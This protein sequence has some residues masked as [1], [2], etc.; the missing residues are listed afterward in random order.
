MTLPLISAD[1]T[2][3]LWAAMFAIAGFSIWS[4]KTKFGASVSGV[5][6]AIALAILASNVMIIPRSAPAYDLVNSY[7]LP[8]AIPM[9][10]LKANLRK[11]IR[12]TKGMLIAFMFGTLGTVIGV[13]IGV[14]L[15]PLGEASH[16]LAGIFSAT[17][18]G[19]SMNMAAVAQVVDIDP[20]LLSASVAADNV[21]GVLYLGVLATMPAIKFIRRFFPSD[22]I[23]QADAQLNES[24]EQAASGDKRPSFDLLHICIML[25]LS[26][27]ICA[28]GKAI[29]EQLSIANY[30]ILFITAITVLI[31]NVFPNHLKKLHGEYQLGMLFMYLFF[32]IA[33]AGADIPLMISGA[34]VLIPFTIIIVF[35]HWLIILGGGKL[36][37]IDL[38]EI[39]IASNACAAGPAPAAAMA[40]GKRW[41]DLVTPAV[42]LGVFGYVIANFIG[43]TLASYLS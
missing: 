9:L 12:E 42:M 32:V 29:A 25:T 33:G 31:A 15:L 22:I 4:E 38:A 3:T 21:I 39:I 14:W 26:F 18:I 28:L 16:Q 1:A 40:A 10:L 37:N 41:P 13:L 43:V 23:I 17:Y 36:F 5:M 34:L 8:L 19:G 30:A 2:F 7:L 24:S 6:V 27:S 11:I 20:T 35:C